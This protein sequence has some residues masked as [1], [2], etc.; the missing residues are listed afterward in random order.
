MFK[1]GTLHIEYCTSILLW[2]F[3]WLPGGVAVEKFGECTTRGS[4]WCYLNFEKATSEHAYLSTSFTE[5][6]EMEAPCSAGNEA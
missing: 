3:Y 4:E 6:Y 1:K 2:W 5:K